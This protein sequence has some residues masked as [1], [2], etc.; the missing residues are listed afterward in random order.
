MDTEQEIRKRL[1]KVIDELVDP[2]VLTSPKWLRPGSQPGEYQF[3][4]AL[5][6]GKA[7]GRK[8]QRVASQIYRRLD[9]A[10]LKLTVSVSSTGLITL[11][12]NKGGAK[13]KGPKG[14]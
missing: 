1:K 9:L 11:T 13:A 5:K 6:I 10:D 12:P 14:K 2:P 8:A 3:I 7:T 4:G